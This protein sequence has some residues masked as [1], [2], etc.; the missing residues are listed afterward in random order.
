MQMESILFPYEKI[1]NIQD[2]LIADINKC[3]IDRMNLVVHAPTGLGKTAASLCPA[4]AYAV[5]NNKT[6]FFLTCRHTQ[7]LVAI[8]TLK[9]IKDKFGINI[10]NTDIIGKKW[11]CP[12]PGVQGLSSGDFYEYCKSQKDDNQCEFYL[13]TR[14]KSG[15]ATEKAEF[16]LEKIKQLCPCD[17]EKIIEICSQENL[18]PYEM[19]A[20]LAQHSKVIVADYYYVFHPTIRQNFFSKAKKELANS[21]LIID[22]GHNLPSRARDLMTSQ[23]STFSI[24]KAVSEAKKFSYK[25][26]LH[27]LR[28][29][30]EVLE[31][32]SLDI[33]EK[34]DERLITKKEFVKKVEEQVDDYDE[35]ISHFELIGEEVREKKKKSYIGSIAHFLESWLGQNEC[36]ARILSKKKYHEK[37]YYSLAYRCLDPSLLTR[38]VLNSSHCS[39]LMSGTLTPT[40]MYKELLGFGNVIERKYNSPFPP[41]NKLSM[42]IPRTTTKFTKRS[43][44]MYESIAEITSDIVNNVP[45]NSAVFFPS[46]SVRDNV[47]AFFQNK[48]D[49]T[50]F[51]EM[52]GISN[53]EKEEIL[54]KFKTYKN[55][56]AVLLGIASG[57]FSQSIDLP[58]DLLKAVVVVGL[59]LE[60]PD[61]ETKELI[62]YYEKKYG[63]GWD[64]G[65][66]FPAI[67]KCL[68]GAG[69]CIRSE[70]D[71]GIIVYLEE[72]F[73]WPNYFKCFPPD[74]NIKIN[75]INFLEKIKEFF[76]NQQK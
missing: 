18:C 73:A 11:M 3:L 19:S 75:N 5:A 44:E 38:D 15:R 40:A 58:G 66:V 16:V 49:K 34:E 70:H 62:D 13:N 22:E 26:A 68:Q 21:I 25:E 8:E 36:F 17:C 48:C 9:M 6:V 51:L 63:K 29:L 7:H 39:V 59:P 12:V 45:G 1:R 55:S 61:L 57:S 47:Y 2:E 43:P 53:A 72:R 69:R 37:E 64:Y 56:G 60:K 30:K 28:I 33:K 42:I 50:V 4:L 76:E 14:K 52:S 41:H 35:L 46:Y 65:Y 32:L 67:S 54:S 24:N 20:I 31:E 10:I 27:E 23:I 71:R 74:T